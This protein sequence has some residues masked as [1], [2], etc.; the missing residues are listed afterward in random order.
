MKKILFITLL[1]AAGIFSTS[2]SKDF[3]IEKPVDEIYS[4]NL[5]VNYTGF[6][7]MISA[8]R[9]LMRN[10]H[11]KFSSG[12]A[13]SPNSAFNGGS[14][15]YFGN[16]RISTATWWNWPNLIVQ[17]TDGSV[18][19]NIFGDMYEMINCSNMII[20]RAENNPDID[21]EGNTAAQDE[22]NKTSIIAQAK[23][24]RAWA[25]RH[26]TYCFGDVP[27]S[28][29][30]ITGSN[31]RTDWNRD[32]VEK[33]REAMIEDLTYCVEHLGW[34]TDGNNT[35]PNQ[36]IARTYLAET[37]LAMNNPQKAADVLQP[38]CE[39]ADY[40]L[41]TSRFGANASNPGN[42][43][44]DVFRTPLYSDGNFEVLYTFMNAEE[45]SIPY[46]T[47]GVCEVRNMY[48]NYYSY[49]P[50][51]SSLSHPDY[52]GKSVKLF[53]SLNGGKG[54]TRLAVSIGAWKLYEW[55]NQQN[56]DIRYDEHSVVK[57]L[58]FLDNNN[59]TYEVLN[60]NSEPLI[61]LN[62]TKAMFATSEGTIKNYTLP[63]TKKWD[64]VHSNFERA[65]TD[66]SFNNVSYMRLSEA[67]FLY[68]EALLKL[69]RPD[70]SALW[71]NKIRSRANVSQINSSEVTIDFILD[72]RARE[73][74]CEG[75]RRHTLMR[76]SQE[77][78]GDERDINNY[79]K[80]RIRTYNE[81]CGQIDGGTSML[82]TATVSHGT[83]QYDVPVLFAIPK[84]FID[85][86][87]KVKIEQN[88][89]YP[90]Y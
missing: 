82:G 58:Y 43:F 9:G 84:V 89:G 35:K 40:Y 74:L 34:R 4:N 48:K 15:L 64:N 52:E 53:W 41:M 59:N 50:E 16:Q 70:E 65:D 19:E 31:Y 78:N 47:T 2:C 21:W 45:E 68:A 56:N 44:I 85:S 72:E 12:T 3:L 5:L 38:L 73:L 79:F 75:Q 20:N 46:G 76:L 26:L 77:N 57:H 18:F 69:G 10:E 63:S 88:P 30:E 83:D 22:I 86:N 71:I 37:Y 28:L 51:I 1:L 90:T 13:I 60:K 8:E 67:Y 33:V 7:S 25:Y 23:F 80:R 62:P 81:V 54:A 27:L 66:Y 29:E 6:Y 61:N 87:T 17:F 36:A 39:G 11:G 42:C 24:Y 49:L 55:D 32:S 14:D